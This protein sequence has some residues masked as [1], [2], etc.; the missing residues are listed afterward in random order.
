MNGKKKEDFYFYYE[1]VI[2]MGLDGELVRDV[3]VFLL[4]KLVFYIIV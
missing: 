3:L 1:N 2:I 4:N